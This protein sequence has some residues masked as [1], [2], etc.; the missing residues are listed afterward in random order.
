MRHIKVLEAFERPNDITSHSKRPTLVLKAIFHSLPGLIRIWWYPL[1]RS[2]LENKEA[3]P[4]WS[5]RSLILGI[6][7]LY[8][9]VNLFMAQL[10]T[11]NLQDPSFLGANKVGT[12]QGL[13]LGCIC[14]FVNKS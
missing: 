2:I 1:F 6:G 12:T 13:K 11:H 8:L 10:S 9:I 7:N 14:P 5:R 4:N 3:P